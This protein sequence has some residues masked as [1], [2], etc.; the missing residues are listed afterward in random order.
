MKSCQSKFRLWIPP[1]LWLTFIYG[2]LGLAR[3]V[4]EYLMARTPFSIL[5]NSGLIAGLVIVLAVAFRRLEGRQPGNITVGVIVLMVYGLFLRWLSIP[6]ERIHLAQYGIL[7]G[8]IWRAEKD[9]WGGW[10]AYLLAWVLASLAGWGD[11]IIQHFIPNRYF[12]WSDVG[13]NVV[14]AG[15][16]LLLVWSFSP[17]EDGEPKKSPAI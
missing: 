14:S 12:Q 5:V 2:T 13:L 8:L 11:E 16:G 17:R 4:S 6:A 3:P 7:A 9:Q 1:I 15:L 10:R